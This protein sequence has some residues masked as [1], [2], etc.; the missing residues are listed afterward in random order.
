MASTL[1]TL[2]LMM[3][4]LTST[5]ALKAARQVGPFNPVVTVEREDESID[6]VIEYKSAYVRVSKASS[7]TEDSNIFARTTKN[8][9]DFAATFDEYRNLIFRQ[10]GS[11]KVYD[12]DR[13]GGALYKNDK[14]YWLSEKF[15]ADYPF[16]SL[17]EPIMAILE[18]GVT[19]EA[20]EEAADYIVKNP[21]EPFKNEG[22]SLWLNQF[23]LEPEKSEYHKYLL[24]AW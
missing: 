22:K 12:F 7:P 11:S 21:R 4:I 19:Q 9:I 15:A 3:L 24:E 8:G 18:K 14:T 2:S 23:L 16:S 1:L 5:E 17:Y 20:C 6:C 13:Y 10:D